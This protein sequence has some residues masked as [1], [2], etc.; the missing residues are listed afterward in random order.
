[1][2]SPPL[3]KKVRRKKQLKRTVWNTFFF[4]FV[5]FLS[6]FCTPRRKGG[7]MLLGAGQRLCRPTASNSL[8]LC[9]SLFIFFYY[10]FIFLLLFCFVG[11][12][13]D[14]PFPLFLCGKISF[15]LPSPTNSHPSL[16]SPFPLP[17]P[18]L[19]PPSLPS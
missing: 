9:F 8:S 3:D 17:S 12:V 5:S 14:N 7:K 4:V 16:P 2:T 19:P 15:P 11:V 13:C 6:F 18:L 1:M 10:F